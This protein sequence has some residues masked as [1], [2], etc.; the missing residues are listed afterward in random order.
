[1]TLRSYGNACADKLNDPFGSALDSLASIET[2][3]MRWLRQT[4]SA[5]E[6]IRMERAAENKEK[7]HG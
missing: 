5:L 2:P 7:G 3:A 1:M 4:E 6:R